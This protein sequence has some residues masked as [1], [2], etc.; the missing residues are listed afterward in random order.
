MKSFVVPSGLQKQLK[1]YGSKTKTSNNIVVSHNLKRKGLEYI[2]HF[3]RR[4]AGRI[5]H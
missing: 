1:Y 3:V 2:S 5:K 4:D